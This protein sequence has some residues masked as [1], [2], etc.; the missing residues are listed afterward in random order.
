[1][2]NVR[3][4]RFSDPYFSA[5]RLNTE[6]D[7]ASFLIQSEYVKI[8]TRKTRNTDTFHAVQKKQKEGN[9][10]G[11]TASTLDDV[12]AEGLKN[13]DCVLILV[14]CLRSLEKQVKEKFDLAKKFIENQIKGEL[15]LQEV[16]KTISFIGKMFDAYEQE[17]R[18][19]EIKIGELNGIVSKMYEQID[20]LESKIDRQ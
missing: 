15:A 11:S 4:R 16:N 9:I 17:R 5:L 12:F 3:T 13:P 10:S 2:K 19:N 1:M 18:E 7:G 8:R 14:N 20:E 6:R